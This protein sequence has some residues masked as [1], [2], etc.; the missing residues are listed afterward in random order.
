MSELVCEEVDNLRNRKLD[1]TIANL[2]R[3]YQIAKRLDSNILD[4]NFDRLKTHEYSFKKI[5]AEKAINIEYI[6]YD[7]IKQKDV[8]ER[9][10]KRI[11]PFQEGGKGYRD[12]LIWMSFLSYLSKK[13]INQEVIFITINNSDFYNNSNDFHDDLKKDIATHKLKCE[14]IQYTSLYDFIENNVDK[15]EHKYTRSE[16]FDQHLNLIDPELERE[17]IDYI[18][19]FSEIQLKV[20]LEN[21][22]S[23]A[24]PYINSLIKHSITLLEG[25]E[26]PEILS[27]T[28]ISDNSIYV[29]FRFNLRIC[30]LKFTIPNS[31]YNLNRQ[32]IDQLYHEIFTD[33]N[34]TTFCAY[35]RTY[36]DVSFEYDMESRSIEGFNIVNLDFE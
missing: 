35:V 34:I 18:N 27:Y 7:D 23:R 33:D 28:I 12:T 30:A 17:S 20:I 5:I 10:I 21:N 1:T 13:S 14:I 16:L 2:K 22:K 25:V 31:D 8:V 6:S 29:S 9:A 24:F 26:D 32:Q 36:L 19:N 15:V 11:K 4:C 3:E